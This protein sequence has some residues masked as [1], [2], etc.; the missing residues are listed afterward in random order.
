VG[1]IG[2]DRRE[3]LYEMSYCDI[4]LIQRGYRRRNI[5]QYQLQ[6]LQAYGAFHCMS[7]SKKEPQEWLPLYVDRYKMVNNDA[8]PISEKE[9]AEL[10][11]DMKQLGNPWKK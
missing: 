6:R 11:E 1:E 2:R 10:L 3:Y 4:L 7:G 8:P 9:M 5:L